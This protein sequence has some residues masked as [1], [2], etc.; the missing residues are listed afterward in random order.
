GTTRST[1][2]NRTRCER[3]SVDDPAGCA[4]PG[5]TRAG[6]AWSKFDSTDRS[7]RVDRFSEVHVL[8]KTDAAD[9][10]GP[11]LQP[12]AGPLDAL[13]SRF[14]SATE[15]DCCVS[16]GRFPTSL[17]CSARSQGAHAFRRC[18]TFVLA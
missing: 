7:P 10:A 1:G 14:G 4:G 15:C 9:D 11:G 5:G 17:G 2:R 8:K 6:G 3:W 18:R 13:R 16:A 12:A